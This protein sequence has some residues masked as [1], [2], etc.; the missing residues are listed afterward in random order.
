MT[1]TQIRRPLL[2]KPALPAKP[3]ARPATAAPPA[4]PATAAPILDMPTKRGPGRPRKDASVAPV[5]NA[6]APTGISATQAAEMQRTIAMQTATIQKLG[7]DLAKL[8]IK[9]SSSRTED[10]LRAGASGL[11]P[12]DW[13]IDYAGFVVNVYQFD[14]PDKGNKIGDPDSMTP[15]PDLPVLDV[16]LAVPQSSDPGGEGGL[17]RAAGQIAAWQEHLPDG[18]WNGPP[19]YFFEAELGKIWAE[20]E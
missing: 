11:K 1:T 2:A 15:R 8:K 6:P 20:Q 10:E 9:P 14:Q 7:E 16:F 5:L 17:A 19:Y 4:R 3:P 12:T 18:S 13:R